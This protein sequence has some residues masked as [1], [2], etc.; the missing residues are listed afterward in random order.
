VINLIKTTKE[1]A[2]ARIYIDVGHG[3]TGEDTGA[4]GI[5][6]SK[7]VN[8]NEQNLLIA[9]AMEK[10]LKAYGHEVILS[11]RGN[12]NCTKPLKKANSAAYWNQPDSNIIGSANAVNAGAYDFMLSIHNNS[13][14]NAEAR[15]YQI[16]FKTGNGKRAESER[17]A[18]CVGKALDGI[19]HKNAIYSTQ[20]E[21]GA[22]RHGILRLH[23]KTGVII[24]AAFM[25]NGKDLA[26]LVENA[27]R[28]GEAIANGVLDFCGTSVEQTDYAV[29]YSCDFLGKNKVEF[30]V[31][32]KFNLETSQKSGALCWAAIHGNKS[33]PYLVNGKRF[34]FE[35]I[36]NVHKGETFTK[37]NGITYAGAVVGSGIQSWYVARGTNT[38][39]VGTAYITI[40][41]IVND[42]VYKELQEEYGG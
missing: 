15:G 18:N 20:G 6:Q 29:E 24:E 33:I 25:S 39:V 27:E 37:S 1:L 32:K 26:F 10:R 9:L 38:N 14:S 4:V 7:A 2:M 16:I 28:L 36:L 21:N 40:K 19:A 3:K 17:L 30:T 31:A 13:S 34:S 23:G 42:E 12:E 8:E 41:G 11:R 35:K 22:D 5:Y